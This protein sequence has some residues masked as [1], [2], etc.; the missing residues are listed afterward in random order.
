MYAL[1]AFL[2]PAF[3]EKSDIWWDQGLEGPNFD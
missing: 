2:F 3:W 1:I